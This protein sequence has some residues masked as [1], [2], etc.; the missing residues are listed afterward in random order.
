MRRKTI[1]LLMLV[2]IISAWTLFVTDVSAKN[3]V[4][5]NNEAVKGIITETT[6]FSTSNAT[7]SSLTCPSCQAVVT[8]QNYT[9]WRIQCYVDGNFVGMVDAGRNLSV[10]AGSGWT[11]PYARALFDDGSFLSWDLGDRY[12]YPGEYYVFP[13]R[14]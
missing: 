1:A 5:T 2:T 11:R 10:W 7:V 9:R 13:M 3:T 6:V 8:F 12:Y 4:T 14:P